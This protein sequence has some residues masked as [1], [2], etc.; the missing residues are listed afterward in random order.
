M[1]RSGRSLAFVFQAVAAVVVL[2][3]ALSARADDFVNK[4]NALYADIAPAKRSDLVLLPLLAKMDPP[5]KSA[6]TVQQAALLAANKEGWSEAAAWAQG[7]N[8]MAI[9]E[10]IALV[11]RE[12]DWKQAYAFGQPYGVE[13]VS[14]DLVRAKLY[15]ELGDP[16]T[17]AAAVHLYLPAL[18]KVN[19]LVN[20]A[21]TGLAAAGKPSDAIDLLINWI[22]FARQMADR[23]FHAEATWALTT[24]ATTQERI[25]DVAYVDSLGPKQLE[26]Q[27]ILEQIKRLSEESLAY[28][29]LDR[30]KF[31]QANHIASQQIVARVYIERNGIND[32]TFASTM[33]RLGSTEHP[34][35]LFSEAARWRTVAGE[36]ANWFDARE[37]VEGVHGDW[38]ARWKVDWYDHL[39]STPTA[40]SMLDKNHFVAVADSTPDMNDLRTLR[41]V[42]R[43]EGVGTRMALAL[44]G[45]VLVNKLLPPTSTAIRPYWMTQLEV[46]PYNPQQG[47]KFRGA[48][49]SLEFFVPIRDEPRGERQAKQPHDMEVFTPNGEANFHV[50]LMDDVFVLYSWGSDNKKGYAKRIQNTPKTVQGAD[51]LMWPPFISLYRQHLI[52][53]G[54]I[55]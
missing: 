29:D 48:R 46:D 19:C 17:L 9:L 6:A 12:S 28:L 45:Y 13:G 7:A 44:D 36:Q 50:K 20:V 15:T 8:Q 22:Y 23:Q 30:M 55:K 49:P 3:A 2:A 31:P 38:A 42:A 26:P 27:R 14:P 34:L 16:P 25:R 24:I 18:E 54:D 4:V 43:T 32:K 10:A 51:Y 11:T 35:R 52:D 1:N 5:P 53:K 21:A 33:S 39:N 40:Y 47:E 41:Q 37:R